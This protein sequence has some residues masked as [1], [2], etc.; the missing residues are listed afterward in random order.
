MTEK[1]KFLEFLEDI[2]TQG[3]KL[4]ELAKNNQKEESIIIRDVIRQKIKSH[5]I[6]L[7]QTS[8][9]LLLRYLDSVTN[10]HATIIYS[11]DSSKE[12]KAT[13]KESALWDSKMHAEILNGLK[14]KTLEDIFQ[15]Y[16][17]SKMFLVQEQSDD[18]KKLAPT[19]RDTANKEIE[20]Y[21]TESY[22]EQM[23]IVAF[24]SEKMER[25]MEALPSVKDD[26]T[27]KD[28]LNTLSLS[29]GIIFKYNPNYAVDDEAFAE[30]CNDRLT[31]IHGYFELE[32]QTQLSLYYETACHIRSCLKAQILTKA[33]TLDKSTREKLAKVL[34]D[35]IDWLNMRM[36]E[37]AEKSGGMQEVAFANY[38]I[39]FLS[40]HN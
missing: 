23:R 31:L 8:A 38:A 7:D 19:L 4:Q 20:K 2:K 17:L 21:A 27:I 24:F 26:P 37:G 18:L 32:R 35:R 14:Y 11:K 25:V 9:S 28:K 30:N 15:L 5:S 1:I 22:S 39:K 12:I 33:G 13:T 6:N 34:S 10:F 29:L 3:Q 16:E 40:T 36:S